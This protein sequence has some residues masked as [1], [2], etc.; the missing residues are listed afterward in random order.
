[1]SSDAKPT[2]REALAEAKRI[3]RYG[4]IRAIFFSLA[5][6]VLLLA[7]PLYMLQ[8]YDRVLSS[9]HVSTLAWLTVIVVFALVVL[10]IFDAMRHWLLSRT[11]SFAGDKVRGPLVERSVRLSLDGVSGGAQPLR[12]LAK[13][14]GFVGGAAVLPFFDAPFAPLYI[15]VIALVHPLLGLVAVAFAAGLFGLSLLN[16]RA[17]RKSA[18]EAGV[19]QARAMTMLEASVRNAEV[20][21]AMGMGAA[22]RKRF[23]ANDEAGEALQQRAGETNA[24]ILGGSKFV[25]LL[26]QASILGFGALLVL[27]GAITAGAMIFASI[28]LGRALQPFEQAISSWKQFL[29]ARSSYHRIEA[30]LTRVKDEPETMSLPAPEGHLEVDG[31]FY[32]FGKGEE[33]LLR[34]ISFEVK[35]G[36]ILGLIGPSA[37]GKTTLCRLIAGLNPPSV[38]HVRLDGSELSNWPR[39]EVGRYIGYLPQDVELFAGTVAENIA[40]LE[41]V[42]PDAVVAAARLAGVHEMILK[43]PDGYD[44]RLG[45]AGQKISAGQR[46]RIGLARALYRSPKLIILDE[47]NANLD[48]EG[49]TALEQALEAMKASGAAVILVAHRQNALQPADKLL[50]LQ[51]G[52]M[53]HYGPK[54]EVLKQMKEGGGPLNVVSRNGDPS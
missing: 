11:A 17:T 2:G 54:D 7:S 9:G 15:L 41:E 38:G 14:K 31:V 12:D 33:P 22:I 40:R 34:N 51:E 43:L 46:Q 53:R 5:V 28:I 16:E 37:S 30:L 32:A 36:E 48:A 6:N 49:E 26:A 29:G 50:V 44:T 3:T 10:G 1:M 45:E 35:P 8:I 42:D 13:V 20:I 39:E 25:R 19:E 52:V 21:T 23:S 24:L 47:P 4:V 18:E 27:Q